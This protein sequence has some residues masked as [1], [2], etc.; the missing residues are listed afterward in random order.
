MKPYKSM[1]VVAMAVVAGGI[2]V[3]NVNAGPEQIRFPR[4]FETWTRYGDVMWTVTTASSIASFI[5]VRL[6]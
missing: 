1:L 2:V 5:P 4:G 3:V 6:W